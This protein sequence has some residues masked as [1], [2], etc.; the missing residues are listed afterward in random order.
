MAAGQNQP[1]L[2]RGSKFTVPRQLVTAQAGRVRRKDG[3]QL[4]NLA[5]NSLS[6]FFKQMQRRYK[7]LCIAYAGALLIP[8]RVAGCMPVLRDR[9]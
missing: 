2:R 5:S 7:P 8:V 9:N 4:L 3:A 1:H 6:V